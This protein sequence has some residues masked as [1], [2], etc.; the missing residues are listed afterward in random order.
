MWTGFTEEYETDVPIVQAALGVVSMPPLVAAVSNAGGMGTL[1][2]VGA[3]LMSAVELRALIAATRSLTRRSFGVNFI[4][5]LVN[6]EHITTCIVERVPVVSFHLGDPPEAHIERLREAGVRVWMQVGSVAAARAAVHAGVDAV[7]AQGS[8]AGGSNRST[9][10][11]MTLIPAVVDAV[12]PVPVLAGGGIAD[13]RGL[14]AAL[15]LGADAAWIGTRFVASREANAR[16]DYKK[17]IVAAQ[18]GDTVMT[19]IFHGVERLRRP[20]RALCNRVVRAWLGRDP[21]PPRRGRPRQIGRTELGGRI[22]PLHE[23]S[24]LLPTPETTGDLDEMCL[25]AGESCALVHDI[26]P[27]AEIVREIMREAREVVLERFG[28]PLPG[29]LDDVTPV[30]RQFGA[31]MPGRVSRID[32]NGR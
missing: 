13:G 14:V 15:A 7:I 27:A 22:V 21:E 6:E 2:A 32:L 4:T 10:G 25:L 9:T 26:L 16:M 24:T 3:P 17:R 23:F 1:G 30:A 18:D 12:T 5:P 28:V 31:A 8:E 11:V 20:V 29:R 19:S